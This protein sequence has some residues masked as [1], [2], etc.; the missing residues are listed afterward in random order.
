MSDDALNSWRIFIQHFIHRDELQNTPKDLAPSIAVSDALLFGPASARHQHSIHQLSI[1]P[2]EQLH[3]TYSQG[4]ERCSPG[5]RE[6][7]IEV[8]SLV[9]SAVY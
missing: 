1:L 3:S 2:V 6:D 4:N 5:R 9:F 8:V 7:P